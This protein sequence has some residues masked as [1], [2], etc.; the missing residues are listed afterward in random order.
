MPYIPR[1]DPIEASQVD[2]STIMVSRNRQMLL[3]DIAHAKHRE[4]KLVEVIGNRRKPIALFVDEAHDPQDK[5]LVGLKRLSKQARLDLCVLSQKQ[6]DIAASR[7][8]PAIAGADK[9][10]FVRVA[11][12]PGVYR[13]G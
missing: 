8:S 5:T 9:A 3:D 12:D 2:A 1:G 4:R 11:H 6:E 13:L 10:E 7:L